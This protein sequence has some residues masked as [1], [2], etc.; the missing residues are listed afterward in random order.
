MPILGQHLDSIMAAT[1]TPR[2]NNC[3]AGIAD[4]L[5]RGGGQARRMFAGLQGLLS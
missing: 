5:C 4:S 2:E 1:Q 3:N